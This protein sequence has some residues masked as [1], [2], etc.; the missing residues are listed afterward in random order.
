[1]VN[2]TSYGE[3][4]AAWQLNSVNCD[5]ELSAYDGSM[6]SMPELWSDMPCLRCRVAK[7]VLVQIEREDLKTIAKVQGS[8]LS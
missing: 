2:C 8:A 1:M 4:L 7:P 3:L 5:H 6:A